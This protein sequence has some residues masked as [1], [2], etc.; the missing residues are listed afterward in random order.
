MEDYPKKKKLI[1][2]Y[3][4]GFGTNHS[5]EFC[6]A[7]LT[8]FVLTGMDKQMH[9]NM[10]LVDIQ[11]E[12][13]TL[14]QEGFLETIK[15][16]GFRTSVIKWFESCLSDQGGSYKKEIQLNLCNIFSIFIFNKLYLFT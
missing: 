16:F 2:M 14:D 15:Y 1:Y 10:I 12:S 9:T 4:S 7:Q 8:D 11:K 6:L 5:T 3:Q 13:Y